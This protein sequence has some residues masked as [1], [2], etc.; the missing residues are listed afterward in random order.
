MRSLASVFAVPLVALS[1]FGCEDSPPLVDDV[2]EDAAAGDSGADAD[3]GA[4]D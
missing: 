2:R 1:L 4:A 3:D